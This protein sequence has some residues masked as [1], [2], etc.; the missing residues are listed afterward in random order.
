V[1]A[2]DADDLG[3]QQAAV[4][5]LLR[6]DHDEWQ[7]E[8]ASREAFLKGFGEKLPTELLEENAG[9]VSRLG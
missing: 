4:N 1:A 5:A 6:I 7:A 3:L 2:L 8:A 9:L